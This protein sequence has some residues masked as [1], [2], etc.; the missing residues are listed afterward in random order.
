MPPPLQKVLDECIKA[1]AAF[2][3]LPPSRR[4][5]IT[6]YIARLKSPKSVDRNVGKAIEFLTGK[7]R[8]LGRDIL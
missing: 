3:A 5:E 8:F 7:A 2:K 1:I 4:L 6:R